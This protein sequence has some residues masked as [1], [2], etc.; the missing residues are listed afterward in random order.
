MDKLIGITTTGTYYCPWFPYSLASFYFC[1]EI[2]VVNGGYDFRNPKEEEYNLPLEQVTQDIADLDIAGKVVEIRD[3]TL[4]D[5]EHKVVLA[6]QKDHPDIPVEWYDMRGVC[7]TLANETAVR[8]EATRILKFDSDQVGYRDAR[9]LLYDKR[10]VTLKQYEFCR[11]IFHLVDPPPDSPW[12][13]SVFTYPAVKGD[14]YGGGMGP[15]IHGDRLKVENYHCAHLRHANPIGL[16]EKEQFMHF[17]GRLLFRFYTNEYG[18]FGDELVYR[19][20]QSAQDLLLMEG[21]PSTVSPPEVCIM[22]PNLYVE[23]MQQWIGKGSS[24]YSRV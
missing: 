2:I 11:D 12:N 20:I 22:T 5:L 24:D 21:T 6:T 13:D 19:T 9:F 10:S 4:E 3:F 7:G 14:F 1:D 18:Q 15:H 16:S 17:Y 8:R 23:E